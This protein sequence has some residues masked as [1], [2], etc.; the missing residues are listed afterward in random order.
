[1][2]AKNGQ[3]M[4]FLL[5]TIVSLVILALLNVDTFIAMRTRMHVENG[6]DAAAL[7][8][9]R[10][11]GSLINEIGRLN[12]EHIKYALEAGDTPPPETEA[13]IEELVLDQRRKALVG[14][15]D[16]LV[17][18]SD[19]AKAN[20][21][22]VPDGDIFAQLL[23]DHVNDIKNIYMGQSNAGDPYPE[24][25][26]GAWAE[27]A[28]AIE[29]AI[30]GGLAAGADN[31]EF[32]S[33]GQFG[34]LL[35]NPQFY[36]AISGRNWCWFHFHA[37]STL[38]EYSSFHDWAPLPSSSSATLDNSEIFSLHLEARRGALT[39]FFTKQELLALI[40]R[41][42]GMTAEDLEE[43]KIDIEQTLL[44]DPEQTWFFF[45]ENYWHKWFE[46]TTLVGEDIIDF[47]IL[48]NIKDVYN[49]R[50]AA[51]IT[52]T[53]TGARTVMGRGGVVYSWSAAAKPFGTLELPDGQTGDVTGANGFVLPCMTDARLVP[54]DS[55]GGSYLATADAEWVRHVRKHLP[56]YLEYGP[57]A[58]SGCGYCDI[59][60]E[61]ENP[62]LRE[63]AKTWL[64]YNS[65]T[66]VRGGG[67]ASGHG[68]TSH[69]H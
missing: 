68:G 1:M 42:L 10:R 7:A 26:F 30:F 5:M 53:L 34:H 47:P 38:D 23:A 40:E 20:G 6:G 3:V 4:L 50:G 36:S 60:K 61:W 37:K 18:A 31:I 45:D 65:H 49:V 27:Y 14:P 52:R 17:K 33:G 54:V 24:P 28:S 51:A 43:K 15:V 57:Y 11:Q 19:A 32:Y 8:A 39:D 12:I 35:L 58:V 56:R 48:G 64:K 44:A 63:R 29:N 66:C 25:Y 59:L 2:K 16:A 21:L 69:G 55:V 62:M 67:G 13:K 9:A 41:H 46:G 22:G